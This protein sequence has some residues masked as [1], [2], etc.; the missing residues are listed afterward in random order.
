MREYTFNFELLGGRGGQVLLGFFGMVLYFTNTGPRQVSNR[1]KTTRA[2]LLT[3]ILS[4]S[5]VCEIK[6]HLS[7]KRNITCPPLTQ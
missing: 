5:G 3:T 7:K 6:Y 1:E 4:Y 2:F